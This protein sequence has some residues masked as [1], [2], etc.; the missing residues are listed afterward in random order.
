[1]TFSLLG[2][3]VPWHFSSRESNSN[4]WSDLPSSLYCKFSA[5][6]VSERM[7]KIWQYLMRLWQ[8]LGGLLFG[9]P[10]ISTFHHSVRSLLWYFK[11]DLKL[12]FFPSFS[13]KDRIATLMCLYGADIHFKRTSVVTR[14]PGIKKAERPER[15]QTVTITLTLIITLT[16]NPN[17]QM[18]CVAFWAFGPLNLSAIS[19]AAG[20]GH[21]I[22]LS[23]TF[24]R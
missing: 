8:K 22:L 15:R 13:W 21:V 12:L 24:V 4:I 3:K 7:L 14:R 9:P 18:I 16:P 23:L 10:C 17:T 11:F 2:A 1:M 6:C 5:E 20:R 19:T